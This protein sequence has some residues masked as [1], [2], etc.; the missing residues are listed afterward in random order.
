MRFKL[1]VIYGSVIVSRWAAVD[2]SV[3]R[4]NSCVQDG[5]Y[6]KHLIVPLVDGKNRTSAGIGCGK[7]TFSVLVKV[8]Q[9]TSA[10]E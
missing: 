10:F 3:A 1:D 5:L 8:S 7:I 4:L 9:L 6:V 2:D